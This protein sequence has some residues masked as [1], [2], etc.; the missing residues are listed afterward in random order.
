MLG[1]TGAGVPEQ[2]KLLE[3]QYGWRVVDFEAIVKK[4]LTEI[5]AFERKPPNNITSSGPCMIGLSAEELAEIK[6]GK[7]FATWKFL[8]WVLEYLGVPLAI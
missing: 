6:E 5:L 8:P 4:K 1:P 7:P 2:A 3:N